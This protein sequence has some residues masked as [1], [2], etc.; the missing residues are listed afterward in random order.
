MEQIQDRQIPLARRNK[1]KFL[2]ATAA[3]LVEE[4]R[5]ME[6][7]W[8]N[9]IVVAGNRLVVSCLVIKDPLHKSEWVLLADLCGA[10]VATIYRLYRSR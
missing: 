3:D 2:A 6:A 9:E 10:S 5:P 8:F 4:S 1:E 7:R